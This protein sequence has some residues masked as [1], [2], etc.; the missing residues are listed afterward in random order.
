MSSAESQ[1]ETPIKGVRQA[2][3]YERLEVYRDLPYVRREIE[4]LA[5]QLA[6]MRKPY[7]APTLTALG[8]I[9]RVIEA[10]TGADGGGAIT[11][12]N[13]SI[14]ARVAKVL[15]ARGCWVALR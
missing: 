14:L 5:E 12:T 4:Q 13:P 1:A 10:A 8:E 11:C 2:T 15:N 6:A 7:H 3:A 9:Q